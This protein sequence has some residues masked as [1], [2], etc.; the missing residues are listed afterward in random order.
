MKIYV[1]K[2]SREQLQITLSFI[3]DQKLPYSKSQ[4]ELDFIHQDGEHNNAN[5]LIYIGQ[6][7][8]NIE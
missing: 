1:F 8:K 5:Q 3:K 2:E 4:R 6:K 7:L